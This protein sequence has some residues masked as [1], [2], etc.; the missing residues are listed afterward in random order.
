MK[1]YTS[2]IVINGNETTVSVSADDKSKAIEALW[3]SYGVT[4]VIKELN[5][6]G[7]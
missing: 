4:I 1:N 7:N 2:V 5:E 3:S 6:I